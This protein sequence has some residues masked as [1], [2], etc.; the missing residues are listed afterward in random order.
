MIKNYLCTDKLKLINPNRVNHRVIGHKS[1][2]IQI[3]F[4][5]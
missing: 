1:V 4:I 3:N 2:F 5:D